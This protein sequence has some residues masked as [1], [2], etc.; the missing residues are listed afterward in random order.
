MYFLNEDDVLL[1]KCNTKL[2]PNHTC[3]A[4]ITLDSALKEMIV[5]IH[6]CFKKI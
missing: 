1:K 3:L 2:D 4:V 6:K 5:I